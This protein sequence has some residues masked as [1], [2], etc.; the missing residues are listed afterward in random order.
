MARRFQEAIAGAGILMFMLST[1]L[2]SG[3]VD[4]LT[5]F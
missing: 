4:R 1:I 3:M 5:A 2:L